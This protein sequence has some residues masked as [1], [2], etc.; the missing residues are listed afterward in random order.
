MIEKC[1]STGIHTF[2]YCVIMIPVAGII[3][4]AF[5][6]LSET[7]LLNALNGNNNSVFGELLL[8]IRDWTIV[9]ILLLSAC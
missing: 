8:S 9:I 4:K 5:F 1:F 2:I 3:I 7:F 6:K